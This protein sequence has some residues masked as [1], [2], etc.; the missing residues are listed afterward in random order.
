MDRQQ[1]KRKS[2]TSSLGKKMIEV[3]VVVAVADSGSLSSLITLVLLDD[4]A[5][6]GPL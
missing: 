2:S 3:S 4:I 5:N 6:I 1:R